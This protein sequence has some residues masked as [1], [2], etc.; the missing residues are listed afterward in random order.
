[1]SG[2]VAGW[3][4]GLMLSLLVLL[5]VVVLPLR[6]HPTV[7]KVQHFLAKVAFSLGKFTFQSIFI[8]PCRGPTTF[9]KLHSFR[10]F[11]WLFSTFHFQRVDKTR[12]RIGFKLIIGSERVFVGLSLFF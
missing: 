10:I 11:A 3:V 7:C 12:F 4:G 8:V 6:P 2:W 1:M 9:F 5:R